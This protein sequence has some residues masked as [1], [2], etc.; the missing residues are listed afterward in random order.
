MNECV[1]FMEVWRYI[2]YPTLFLIKNIW[3]L[4]KTRNDLRHA[5][6]GLLVHVCIFMVDL[7]IFLPLKQHLKWIE[8]NH[9]LH[10]FLQLYKLFSK[11][12][13]DY[14]VK[15]EMFIQSLV[16][17]KNQII[18]PEDPFSPIKN[19]RITKFSNLILFDFNLRFYVLKV[20]VWSRFAP[21]LRYI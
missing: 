2:L 15:Q 14:N 16:S 21:K 12:L 7:Q 9:T 1:H 18:F 8:W 19:S 4:W 6:F 20:I 11:W 17:Q 10:H 3:S 13:P 5:Q